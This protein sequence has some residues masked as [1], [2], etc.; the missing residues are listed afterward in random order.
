MYGIFMECWVAMKLY[1]ANPLLAILLVASAIYIIVT[2]KDWKK[3]ILLGI[4]PMV[5]LVGFL[6]PVTKIVYVAA[7]DEGSDTYYRVLWLV[8]MYMVIG[9]AVCKLVSGFG[10][11]VWQRVALVISLV[12]IVLSGSLVYLNQYMS[13]AE[14]LYHIPQHVVDICDVIKP[15]EGE[16]RVRAAFPS[17]LVHY[18][19][20]YDTNILMPFGREMVV[21][22]WDYYNMVY[23]VMEKP[24][25]INAEDLI[26]ATRQ[27]Q[28]RYIVLAKDRKIDKNLSTLGLKLINTVDKYYIYEDPVVAEQG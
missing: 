23:E 8:P 17:E 12:V 4:L 18:V 1:F 16:A 15:D 9:Y 21:T 5:I 3:K 27:T 20:Q 24:D 14:N 2:E 19:R 13:V 28:C 25:V 11:R 7:F 6:F 10:N 26:E 22:Q